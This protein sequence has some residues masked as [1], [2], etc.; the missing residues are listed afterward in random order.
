MLLLAFA[1][2]AVTRLDA[3][4]TP[5]RRA[6]VVGINSYGESANRP[7]AEAVEHPLVQRT[8]V[9][10]GTTKR[11]DYPDLEGA[12]NDATDF[13]AR[14]KNK[15]YGFDPK[16]IVLLLENKA[17]AQNI[18]D[19][20]ER[21]LVDESSCPGDVSLFFY[22]GH[23]SE[24]RNIARPA[25]STDAYDQTLVPYDAIDGA[26]DIRDKE[27]LRL[28]AAAVKK[29]IF[30]TVIL[31]SCHSG[32][33]SRGAAFGGR[34]KALPSPPAAQVNDPAQ[35]LLDAQGR[36]IELTKISSMGSLAS[37]R[38]VHP[39]LMLTGA[40]EKDEAKEDPG[41]PHHGYFTKALLEKLQDHPDNDS[42]G[43]IFGDVKAGVQTR[44]TQRPEIFGE[45]RTD[46]DLFGQPARPSH[47]LVA[48]ATTMKPDGTWNLD[49]G[50]VAGLNEGCELI[51]A[52]DKAPKVRLRIT[53]ANLADSEA[54]VVDGDGNDI[55]TAARFKLDKFVASTDDKAL[56]VYYEKSGP[57]LEALTQAAGVLKTLESAGVRIVADPTVETPAHQIWWI[58]REWQWIVDPAS[59][60]CKK[61]GAA[62]DADAITK[63]M[64][65]GAKGSLWVNFP[66]PAN[67]ASKLSIGDGT[68]ND[69]V[70]VPAKIGQA[71]YFLAGQRTDKG[72]AYAW[73]KPGATEQDQKDLR[74]PV[75]SDWISSSQPE[76]ESNL[77]AKA[78]QLNRIN[79]WL[80]LALPAGGA[81][82]SE[83]PYSMQIRRVGSG[84]VMRS[85]ESITKGGEKFKVWLTA[86]A[87]DLE[88]ATKRGDIPQRWIYVFA[89]DRDGTV[90]V[91]VPAGGEANVGNLAPEAGSKPLEIQL[92]S[93]PYDFEVGEPFGIDTYMILAT[94]E[95]IDPR[96]LAATG[97]RSRS[98]SRGNPNPLAS[99]LGNVGVRTRAAKPPKVPVDW[100]LEQVTL[101]SQEK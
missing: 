99:L 72:F 56:R 68:A 15:E 33:M 48:R 67:S 45:G 9:V 78:L 87:G 42:I 34:S 49:K 81:D 3:Q 23:G 69:A 7:A 17:T 77:L 90:D 84:D 1:S 11:G 50:S 10:V 58:D 47:G 76:Y 16:N 37:G 5:V 20:F 51:T 29:G 25:N 60:K 4:C 18:L 27:L 41:E 94:K 88:E 95:Q 85:G 66:L 70:H 43:S 22:S 83:F 74:L 55:R 36:P 8:P 92:T 52:D 64:M 14:L 79:G 75:R 80:N 61:L 65:P 31:D 98:V 35:D 57:S 6:L 54:E 2:L 12:V 86:K 97:V 21:K 62:L 93:Q 101:R 89:V 71:D 46:S 28:Y 53:K 32:G 39:V 63:L 44:S 19:T 96:V 24:I 13:S 82:K 73:I 26:A 59:G 30:L 40:S 100:S 91:I 38:P